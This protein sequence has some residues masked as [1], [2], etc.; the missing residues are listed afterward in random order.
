MTFARNPDTFFRTMLCTFTASY[1]F[2][3][4]FPLLACENLLPTIAKGSILR[5]TLTTGGIKAL[6]FH[7]AKKT[8]SLGRS[9]NNKQLQAKMLYIPFP[10]P[11]ST[12][13]TDPRRFRLFSLSRQHNEQILK[14][15]NSFV[16]LRARANHELSLALSLF[17]P[18]PLFYLSLSLYPFAAF[19]EIHTSGLAASPV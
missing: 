19:N 11:S 2:I 5:L 10:W 17:L 15:I 9:S 4:I 6:I 1:L 14:T 12:H 18:Q 13:F 16:S 7:L 3:T 8:T